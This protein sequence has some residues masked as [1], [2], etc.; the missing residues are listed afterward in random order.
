MWI[1]VD[2]LGYAGSGLL[3][4]VCF[5]RSGCLRVCLNVPLSWSK[6]LL[7]PTI[8]WIGWRI[9][10]DH[11]TLG[12]DEDKRSRLLKQIYSMISTCKFDVKTVEQLIGRLL[13]LTSAWHQLRPLLLPFYRV[14]HSSPSSMFAV[15]SDEWSRILLDVTEDCTIVLSTWAD[16]LA[17]TSLCISRL[18]RPQLQCMAAADAMADEHVAGL[19]GYI[20]FPSGLSGWFQLKITHADFP[21]G[22][23]WGQD[24]LQKHISAFELLAQCL[25]LQTCFALLKFKRTHCL[26]LTAC[27]N[28]A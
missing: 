27:D 24:S 18:P 3:S 26:L 4:A 19:G 28:S 15:N 20:Q 16:L 25:L 7:C 23:K 2:D 12:I 9:S 11:W 14:L 22:V 1:Y 13:R 17:S 10:L 5:L 8:S 21:T 6:A